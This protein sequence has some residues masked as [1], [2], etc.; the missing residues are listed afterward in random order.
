MSDLNLITVVYNIEKEKHSPHTLSFFWYH[1]LVL[2]H[3]LGFYL[4]TTH[5]DWHT[6]AGVAFLAFQGY[7]KGRPTNLSNT[8]QAQIMVY[9][10]ST[11]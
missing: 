4:D 2:T 8:V 11:R 6:L 1:P 7:F 3:F 10:K 5:A 9:N